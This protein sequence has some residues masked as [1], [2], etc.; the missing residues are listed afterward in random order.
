MPAGSSAHPA[1]WPVATR[2]PPTWSHSLPHNRSQTL[3]SID[4]SAHQ[5]TLRLGRLP[6]DG[7]RLM[8]LSFPKP[9]VRTKSSSAPQLNSSGCG[10]AE[11]HAM[12]LGRAA[13]NSGHPILAEPFSDSSASEPAQRPARPPEWLSA[14]VALNSSPLC[15]IQLSSSSAHE[16]SNSFGALPG[17]C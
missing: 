3:S 14:H 16:A 17:T 11:R 1:T 15:D 7:D 2:W 13:S 12:A 9:P 4:P 5:L 10:R 6:S 8:S